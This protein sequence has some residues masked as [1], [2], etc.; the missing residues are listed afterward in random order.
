[1]FL[2]FQQSAKE[3]KIFQAK[4]IKILYQLQFLLAQVL[5]FNILS[6]SVFRQI[7]FPLHQV[8]I[9]KT[10]VLLQLYKFWNSIQ[11]K[12]VNKSLYIVNIVGMKMRL[13]K[14]QDDNKKAKK[15]RLKRLSKNWKNIK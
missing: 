2:Y 7:L 1:M 4:N 12:L 8:F 11:S 15:L 5:R 6:M 9:D 13:P 14:L 3:E 10:V